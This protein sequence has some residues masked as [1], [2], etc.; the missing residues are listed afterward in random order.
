LKT[1][2]GWEV[3]AEHTEWLEHKLVSW[4]ARGE[5]VQQ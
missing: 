2:R 4:S 1:S 3:F 5:C